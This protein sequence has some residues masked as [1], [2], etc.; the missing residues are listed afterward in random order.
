M[1]IKKPP[2]ADP[3]SFRERLASRMAKKPTAHENEVEAYLKADLF[4]KTNAIDRKSTPLQWWKANA[5]TYPALS[6]MACAYLGASGSLC[7]VER[8]FLSAAD[9]CM[10]KQPGTLT[11][12]NHVTMRKQPDVASGRGASH[13][14]F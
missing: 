5:S 8:V 6:Q 11:P 14:W 13:W 12:I 9:M 4:F 7:S 2:T 3:Q 10:Y 1:E